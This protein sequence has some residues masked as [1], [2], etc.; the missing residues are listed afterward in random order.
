[1]LRDYQRRLAENA[2][3]ILKTLFIVYLSIEMRVGKTTIALETVR[4][5][6]F[7]SVLFL[8]KKKAINS[9]YEDYEREG[10][11]FSIN[12]INFEQLRNNLNKDYDLL[13]IDESHINGAYPKPNQVTKLIREHFNHL[14]MIMLSGTPTPESYSQIFHQFWVSKY[15]PFNVY[16]N[17][18]KWAK[19]YVIV[20]QRK[21]NGVP[22]NDYKNALIDKIELV[23]RKYFLSYT[24]EEAGFENDEIIEE[25]INIAPREDA[26]KLIKKIVKDRYYRFQ[27][28]EEIVCDSAV[29]LQSKIHQICS[30]T[31]I[32]ESGQI[33][34]IDISKAS[35]IKDKYKDKKIAIFYKYTAEGNVLK[36]VLG[37]TTESPE[38]FNQSNNKIF[39]SQIRAGSMG[40]NLS[41]ADILIFYNID[42]SSLQ[43][44]QARS[45]LQSM[46][47][48]TKSIVH[49]LFIEG[50]I[51][52]KIM[53]AVIK[54]KDYTTYY[55]KKDF[56][57]GVENTEENQGLFDRTRSLCS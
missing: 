13:I 12:V 4:L 29:K 31:V 1:M 48:Q 17:F 40:I 27:D 3:E 34:Y 28:G 46:N 30:G 36:K 24:R 25:I 56:I 51:E 52:E 7:K 26:I 53:K 35:Y 54:K 22:I 8:T 57:D 45:R 14:P 9:I 38:E 5:C 33:K 49:W 37:N 11:E 39:I 15:S 6:G 20:T 16:S 50:G 41:T 55:F 2:S 43:Y 44:W 18:Y 21:I 32:T 42:F 10:F 19:D 47:R 23:I